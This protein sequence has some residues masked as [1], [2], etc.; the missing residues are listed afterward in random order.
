MMDMGSQDPRQISIEAYDYTLPEE[1][2]AKYPLE[3]RDASRLLIHRD[4]LIHETEFRALPEWLEPGTVLVFNNTRVIHARMRFRTEQGADIEIF[5]LEPRLPAD[6]RQSFAAMHSVT[7]KTLIGNNRKWKGGTLCMQV[8]TPNG[9]TT[10]YA[11]RLAR[12]EDA[13]EV[14]FS[15]EGDLAFGEVLHYAG[16]IPLPPYLH[17]ESASVDEDRYQTVYAAEAGSVA[18]PTAGLH[19]TERVL[20]KLRQQGIQTV[21]LT[22]HVGAG[23]FKPVSNGPLANHH[24]HQEQWHITQETLEILRTAIEQGKTIISVGTT[25]MRVL[26]SLFWAGMQLALSPDAGLPAHF[27]I[28]QW[29][30]YQQNLPAL[31]PEAALE[32]LLHAMRAGERNTL[33]GH[34]QLL[35][36]PGY[37]LKI[38]GGLITNFHQPKS[39]LLLLVAA[40]IGQRWKTVYQYA[41][42]NG[43]RFLSY[44]DSS[45]LLP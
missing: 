25:S 35:I 34:T 16:L 29:A 43:F 5:C 1:R 13:F 21:Y 22:L 36:A 11:E 45:L 7:W 33:E 40:I 38:T 15:W 28:G 19:F 24:M 39:T 44:G 30:P 9:A 41:M 4:G 20:E 18:A 10:L 27:T 26:E 17:R 3:E 23:T 8:L 14:Q 32:K 37:S 2:I 12:Y 42:E 31:R 6:Y